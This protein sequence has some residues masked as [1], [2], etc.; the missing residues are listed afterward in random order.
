MRIVFQPLGS[1]RRDLPTKEFEVSEA[2]ED[3]RSLIRILCREIERAERVFDC[4]ALDVRPGYVVFVN[5]IDSKL[6]YDV[7]DFRE[8]ISSSNVVEVAVIPVIHGG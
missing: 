3:L 4:E 2:L 5:R 1:L 8:A 7:N 6:L